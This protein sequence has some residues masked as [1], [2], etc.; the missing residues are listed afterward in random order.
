M[1]PFDWFKQKS[2]FPSQENLTLSIFLD[3]FA[4]LLNYL[5][6]IKFTFEFKLTHG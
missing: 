2:V 3:S 4:I 1:I 5:Y 6:R